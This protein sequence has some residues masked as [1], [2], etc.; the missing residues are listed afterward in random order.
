MF[1]TIQAG[2]VFELKDEIHYE[3]E[4]AVK[5]LFIDQNGV[6]MLLIAIDHS[7]LPDHPAP[8]DALVL[9]LEGEGD[10]TYEG[11]TSHLSEKE[12]FRFDK[13]AIH[14]VKAEK[15]KFMLLFA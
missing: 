10:I 12:A 13:G 11:R 1:N 6:K 2:N 5:Q 7:E 15:M 8:A 14:S 4:K 3:K 9:V